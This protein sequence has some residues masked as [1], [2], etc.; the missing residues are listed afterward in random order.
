MTKKLRI[1]FDLDGIIVDKPPLI[2][3]KVLE[4]L[5]RGNVDNHLHYRFPRSKI[6]QII[7]KLSHFYLFRPPIK[8]NI[9]FINRLAQKPGYELY[10]VSGR[11][12][13]L[14]K[15]TAN[16]LGK[17]GL[18]SVFKKVYLN[19][20]NDQPHLFKEEVLKDLK[21]DIFVDDD[22]ALCDYLAQKLK[23]T[24]IF[25]FNPRSG[26]CRLAISIRSLERLLK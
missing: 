6:E 21:A 2:P 22:E 3:K 12:S 20:S 26:K 5:F 23:A 9:A 19:K 25:C 11:Y 8:E 14:K 16:W 24:K 10:I 1:V 4:W 7:R 18:N 17:R 15:E 13:F